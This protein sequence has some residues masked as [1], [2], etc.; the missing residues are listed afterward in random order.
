MFAGAIWITP[1]I[2]TRAD[3]A[4]LLLAALALATLP[5]LERGSLLAALGLGLCGGLGTA[6][7]ISALPYVCAPLL[8]A[9]LHPQARRGLTAAAAA[10]T[11][12]GLAIPYLQ[13]QGLFIDHIRF[14]AEL[15]PFGIQPENI[16]QNFMFVAITVAAIQPW[17]GMP[18]SSLDRRLLVGLII[19]MVPIIL[20]ATTEGTGLWHFQPF[21]PI[22]VVLVGRKFETA[23]IAAVQR[24][25]LLAL[26]AILGVLAIRKEYL[27]IGNITNQANARAAARMTLARFIDDHPNESIAI[28]DSIDEERSSTPD[29]K[30]SSLQIHAIM[31]L[32]EG[33]P[34]RY[35]AT[36]FNDMR[37]NIYTARLIEK[38]FDTCEVKYWITPRGRPFF[39]KHSSDTL[40]EAFEHSY[41]R[42]RQTAELQ[43][44]TCHPLTD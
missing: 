5:A 1:L 30:N 7:K 29:N 28:S 32:E 26:L 2:G 11:A 23:Q 10:G 33:Q 13:Q 16:L 17:R 42:I 43:V 24:P 35:T 9:L 31:L 4:L 14:L 38:Q 18:A 19:S 27:E 8:C 6:L 34:L 3:P 36:A 20:V 37:S 39:A 15:R 21:F 22:I 25:G 40:T 44:W 12:I 41:H